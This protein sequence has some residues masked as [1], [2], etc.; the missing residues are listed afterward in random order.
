[1]ST[2]TTTITVQQTLT[3][4]P[5]QARAIA[6][7][8]PAPAWTP[9]DGGDLWREHVNETDQ[10]GGIDTIVREV[11]APDGTITTG[12]HDLTD[13]LDLTPVPAR[14]TT[15]AQAAHDLAATLNLPA[16]TLLDAITAART[17]LATD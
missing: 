4:T 17:A 11:I 15:D 6:T 9:T 7:L 14:W 3:V 10:I 5:A 2:E 16:D 8:Q 13:Y 1:M 12:A